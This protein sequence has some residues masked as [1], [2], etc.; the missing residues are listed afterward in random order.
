M[1]SQPKPKVWNDF[2]RSSVTRS[3]GLYVCLCI[4]LNMAPNRHLRRFL[5]HFEKRLGETL[6]QLPSKKTWD[7]AVPAKWSFLIHV[8]C[9]VIMRFCSCVNYLSTSGLSLVYYYIFISYVALWDLCFREVPLCLR[10]H[11]MQIPQCLQLENVYSWYCFIM[12]RS[13]P[14]LSL[15]YVVDLNY[16]ACWKCLWNFLWSCCQKYISCGIVLILVF[17]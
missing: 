1:T 11:F 5:D 7:R 17:C 3:K 10:E 2:E 15:C 8:T 12:I 6:V 14:N 16:T 9:R 13:P 4:N